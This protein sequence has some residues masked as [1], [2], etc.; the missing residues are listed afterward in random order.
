MSGSTVELTLDVG[1]EHEE[2]GI[3]VSYTPGTNPIRDMPGNDAEA[4]SREPVTNETPDT[5]APGVVSLAIT[6]NPGGI[7][8]MRRRTGSR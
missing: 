5:T 3:Q 2:A 6:S 1:A 8:F 4:L 7:R